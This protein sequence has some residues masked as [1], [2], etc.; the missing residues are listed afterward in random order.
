MLATVPHPEPYV[1]SYSE[2]QDLRQ[3][4]LKHQMKWLERWTEPEESRSLRIGRKWHALHATFWGARMEG[5][6]WRRSYQIARE[7]HILPK[8]G[9]GQL[10][11]DEDLLDWMF[12]GYCEH[13]QPE[14]SGWEILAVEVSYTVP[15]WGFFRLKMRADLIVRLRGHREIW[16]V[17]EKSTKN[18]S[19]ELELQL[20]AQFGLYTWALRKR[21]I[22]VWGSI[23][24]MSRTQRNV[25]EEK[26]TLESRFRRTLI[27]HHPKQLETMAQ[28]AWRDMHAALPEWPLRHRPGTRGVLD[29]PRHLDPERCRYRCPLTEPCIAG[30]RGGNMRRFMSD[31]GFTQDLTRH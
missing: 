18:L 2:L 17:D 15:A 25:H 6:G 14:R 23:H 19:S 4:P 31:L 16:L 11:E 30:L 9:G 20:D 29:A 21:G 5:Q 13:W 22:D 8:N 3:C 12:R 1:F 7:L 10:G 27:H 24:D 28:D 26:Q